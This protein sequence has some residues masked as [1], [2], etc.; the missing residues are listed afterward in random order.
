[1]NE[2]LSDDA[3]TAETNTLV[4]VEDEQTTRRSIKKLNRHEVEQQS[5]RKLQPIDTE[6]NI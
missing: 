2:C 5:P 6:K 4:T 3:S 1:M